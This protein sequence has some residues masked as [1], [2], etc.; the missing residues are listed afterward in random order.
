MPTI[1][2][3]ES[4]RS[5]R[6]RRPFKPSVTRDGDIPGLCLIV[7]TRRAFWALVYQP[8]GINPATGKRWGGGVRHELGDAMLVTVSEARAAAL[9]AKSQVRQ[10]RSPH[11][12][13]MASRANVEA[14]R[15]IVPTTVAEALDLYD[16][17]MMVRRQQLEWTR[18]QSVR[19]ARLACTL[20][21]AGALPIGAVTAVM[22]RLLIDTTQGSGAQRTHVYGGLNRFLK[23][24]RKQGLVEMNPCDALDRSDRPKPGAARQHVP[25]IATLRA[26]WAAVESEPGGDLL[27]FLLLLPLR[28]NEASGLRWSE[29]DFDQGR[30]RVAANRTKGGKRAQELPLSPPAVAILERRTAT[31]VNDLVF[32][33]ADGKPFTNWDRLITRIRRRIGE[34]KKDRAARA[35]IH[36]FRRAFVSHLAGRSDVDLLDQCLGHTRR[37]V[38]GV[39]QRSARW[40]ERVAALNAWADLI[41]GVIEDRNVV[42]FA[43][44]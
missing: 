40:P 33:S 9:A 35:S 38:L 5:D 23:W 24:C 7:T 21:N 22:V 17:A 29:V 31:A 30:I 18:K 4:V 12:E 16:R 15:A 41:L 44:R 3:T 36:D 32:P 19:Y 42:S 20:M 25:S 28:R 37:G 34:D 6:L 27:R 14:S 39:Y 2:I 13:A 26:I 11:H 10:G 1:K 8:R 43:R